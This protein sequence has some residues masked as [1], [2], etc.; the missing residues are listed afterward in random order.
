MATEAR[1]RRRASGTASSR[2][3]QASKTSTSPAR[4]P[5]FQQLAAFTLSRYRLLPGW[6]PNPVTA[7]LFLSLIRVFGALRSPISDCDETFNYWEP[8]HYMV[9]G[10]G[11][12]TWE[13]AP[14]FAL[15]SYAFLLPYAAV[16]RA[17]ARLSVSKI[18]AF[19]AIRATQAL[20]HAFAETALYDSTVFRFGKPRARAA[21]ALMIASPGTFRAAGEVLPSSFAMVVL[22]FAFARW[23]V[24]EFDGAVVCIAVASLLGWV[25]VVVL[26][27]PIA[28][29]YIYRRGPPVFL[30]SAIGI[31][32]PLVLVMLRVDYRYYNKLVLVPLRH[33]LYNVF[34]VKGAGPDIFGVEP[35]SYYPINLVLNHPVAAPLAMLFPLQALLHLLGAGVWGTGK[36]AF[37]RALFLSPMYILIVMFSSIPHKEERFLVPVYPLIALVAGVSLCDWLSFFTRCLPILSTLVSDGSAV[38]RATTPVSAS[39][40]KGTTLIALS[41]AVALGASRA[42][43]QIHAYNAPLSIYTRLSREELRN[44]EG[45]IGDA[46][47]NICVGKEW[48]RFP[49]NFFLPGRRFRLRFVK[50][51][52]DGLLPKYFAETPWGT[53]VEQEGMNM[54][55]KEDP[56]Q[57]YDREVDGPCHYYIDLDLSLS[58]GS[59]VASAN[60]IPKEHRAV[61]MAESFLDAEMSPAGFRAFYV[62]GYEDAL[63]YGSYVVVRNTDLLPMN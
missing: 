25:Y 37:S 31:A 55:N 20:V 36:E 41:I 27:I 45:F 6:S 48:Y 57:W 60:P 43:M 1:R 50:D 26:G 40:V 29:H 15:R 38:R 18:D 58:R 54:F 16:A 14:R 34:P 24:G 12:Q 4:A 62:P 11:L 44:G 59:D 21:L 35:W 22:T 23:L 30:K 56:K 49:G 32:V 53:R 2:E 17:A 51:G 52:F 13:Y 39:F 19:Y 3:S 28:L 7:F 42:Y 61:V 33:I 63:K 46:D 8:L 9:H 47:I 10:F 5:A